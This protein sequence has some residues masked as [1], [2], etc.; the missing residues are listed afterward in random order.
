MQSNAATVEEYLTQL[1]DARRAAISTVREV[2]LANLDP[3]IREE[4]AYGM[5]GYVIPHSVYPKGYHCDPKQ[6]LPVASLA[7]QKN[8]NSLYL[9]SVYNGCGGDVP[10]DGNAHAE[11]FK[12]AWAATGK[13]LDMGKCCIRFKRAEDLAL[14]V[15]GEAF[16]R[17]TAEAFIAGYEKALAA[18]RPERP[19]KK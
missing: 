12:A 19:K 18:P 1:P 15:I 5:I 8:Y 6:P 13:K 9:M 7:A 14:E 2:V 17:V 10:T 3:L 16:R 11:W 4:M